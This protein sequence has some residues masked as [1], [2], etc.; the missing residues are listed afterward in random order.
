V[1]AAAG[2]DKRARSEI[3]DQMNQWHV[4]AWSGTVMTTARVW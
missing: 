2:H 3:A 1:V 4:V